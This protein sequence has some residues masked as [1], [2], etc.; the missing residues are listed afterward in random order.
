MRQKQRP[1]AVLSYALY[2]PGALITWV[3]LANIVEDNNNAT[4]VGAIVALCG[5]ACFI[6]DMLSEE[7][8]N[9]FWLTLAQGLIP[10]SFP[11][12]V[13]YQIHDNSTSGWVWFWTMCWVLLASGVI[14]AVRFLSQQWKKHISTT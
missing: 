11:A 2:V 14:F 3:I 7:V 5:V 9:G 4:A 1:L 12:G 10:V 13:L 8:K 6:W